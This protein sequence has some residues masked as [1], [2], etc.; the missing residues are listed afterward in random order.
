MIIYSIFLVYACS[1]GISTRILKFQERIQRNLVL[2][3]QSTIH[4]L[5]AIHDIGLDDI[6]TDSDIP[7]D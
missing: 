2:E 3:N 4:Y 5:I 6:A 1:G 7:V